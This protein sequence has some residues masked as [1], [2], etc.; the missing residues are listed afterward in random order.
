MTQLRPDLDLTETLSEPELPDYQEILAAGAVLAKSWHLGESAFLRHHRVPDE[1]AFKR[2]AMAQ[3]RV[4]LHAQI[5]YRDAKISREAASRIFGTTGKFGRPPDRYGICLDWSMGFPRDSRAGRQRGTGLI[6]ET[7]ED[8]AALTAAAPA[9]P[10]FGDFVLGFPGACETTC[11]ALAAGSSSIGNLGQYFTFRLPGDDDDVLATVETLK[12]LALIAAQPQEILVHSNLDDGFAARFRDHACTL[13][14]AFVERYIVEDL[15]GAGISHCFGHHF[16]E[17]LL[18]LALQRALAKDRDL[19]GTMIYGETVAYRGTDAANFAALGSYLTV[20]IIG[21]MT[22]PS[23]HAVNPV[24]VTENRRIPEIDEICDAFSFANHLLERCGDLLPLFDPAAVD[25]LAD[26]LTVAAKA[27]Q[28]RL[29]RGL[30][31]AG[32]DLKDPLRLLLVLRRLGAEELEARFGPASGGNRLKVAPSRLFKDL[33]HDA[34]RRAEA[35]APDDRKCLAQARPKV[36]TA[37]SDVHRFGKELLDRFLEELGVEV[38][39]GGIST[40]PAKLAE[41]AQEADLIAVSTYNG[42]ALD[43]V[44]TLQAEL[45]K[46]GRQVKI[47]IGGRL[48]QI[49]AGSNTSIPVAVDRELVEAG[50]LVCQEVE[51]IVEPLLSLA[52]MRAGN[53][54]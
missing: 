33:A 48:N 13:G 51:D 19:P 8:F 38:M 27:F 12:A 21:Q 10:H 4:M 36:C 1:A 50:V 39:E 6:L 20:D 40:D 45:S 32:L 9:A 43:F 15:L 47:C 26:R 35:L 28:L 16:S 41:L 11:A 23:G 53:S 17:P 7:P 24:P 25:A 52:R 46:R 30:E 44:T 54:R 22:G 2:T 29:F 42:V 34:R 37:T 5:G 3:R 49:P 18:R 14:M 31:E